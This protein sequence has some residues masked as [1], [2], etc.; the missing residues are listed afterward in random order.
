ML[1]LLLLGFMACNNSGFEAVAIRP[2]SGWADG[3][4]EITVTG[5]GFGDDTT[6]KIGDQNV[7]GISFPEKTSMDYGFMVSGVAPASTIGKGYQDVTVTTGDKTSVITGSGAYYYLECPG[8]VID[9]VSPGTEVSAGTTIQIAGCGLTSEGVKARLLDDAGAQVG[10]DKSLTSVCGTGI[11]S[12]EAP[13]APNGTYYL[14]LVDGDGN[15]VAG[16]LCAS[17]DSGGDSY[18]YYDS[19]AP[20]V[21]CYP[22]TYG[23]AQ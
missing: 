13:D 22:I 12:F 6:V 1:P 20:S 15:A 3:C 18:Y 16:G 7:T 14:Q 4:N 8:L 10:T 17:G 19:G 23:G 9:S 21:P 11:V 2:I 5:R